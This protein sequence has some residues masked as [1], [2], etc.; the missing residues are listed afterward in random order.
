MK[1]LLLAAANLLLSLFFFLLWFAAAFCIAVIAINVFTPESG[2]VDADTTSGLI[3]AC[4]VCSIVLTCRYTPRLKLR[5][6]NRA[7]IT[8]DIRDILAR[9]D[10]MDGH[11]F[12]YWCADLLRKSGF[13]NVTVT[14][15][16]G[17]QGVDILAEK[18]RIRYAVQCKCYSRDLGNKPVQEVNS[19]KVMPQYNCQV[20]AVIT[21]RHFTKGARELAAATGT[22]LWDRDWIL[23]QLRRSGA[24]GE[25]VPAQGD[26]F[27]QAVSVILRTGQ[28][29]ASILERH[30]GIDF[31]Q[32]YQLLNEMEQQGIVGPPTADAPRKI[33]IDQWTQ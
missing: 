2:T 27:Q 19:G 23:T 24:A 14:R 26:L 4:F 22:L 12:E 32:A 7:A 8:A 30:L 31:P 5:P 16:S 25:D 9:I 21:N 28:A 6:K 29:S 15:G 1:K 10:G 18:D 3:M 13:R 17:D 20:G 11:E 33:L